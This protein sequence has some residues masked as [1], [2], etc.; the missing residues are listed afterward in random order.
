MLQGDT[1]NAKTDAETAFNTSAT[2]STTNTLAVVCHAIG[3]TAGYNEAVDF[4]ESY[5]T[6][7]SDR[8]QAYVD[9]EL[10]LEQLFLEGSADVA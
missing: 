8:T 5:S 3:D 6:Q 7:L 4:L 9:G 1:A 10:T 2:V